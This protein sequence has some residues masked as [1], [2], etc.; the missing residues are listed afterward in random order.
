MGKLVEFK[1]HTY[2][3]KTVSILKSKGLKVKYT[4]L[5]DGPEK[6]KLLQLIRDYGLQDEITLLGA[7]PNEEVWKNLILPTSSL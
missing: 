6:E 2:G 4:I 7:L 5:G 1:G 3:I